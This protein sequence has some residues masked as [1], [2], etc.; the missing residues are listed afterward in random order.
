ME[1]EHSDNQDHPQTLYANI[2]ETTDEEDKSETGSYANIKEYL[3]SED[4][5][6]HDSSLYYNLPDL[7]S[8]AAGED[9]Y[10]YMK[11]GTLA[12]AEQGEAAGSKVPERKRLQSAEQLGQS[13]KYVNYTREQQL[14]LARGHSSLESGLDSV[15]KEN[16]GKENEEHDP[17]EEAPLYANCDLEETEDL[18]SE[19]T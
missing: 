10:V 7:G 12:A 18:Y 6:D 15:G 9:M 5:Q 17:S 19:V 14:Q 8:S 3:G 13:K 16:E 1:P 11:P 2:A 4:E